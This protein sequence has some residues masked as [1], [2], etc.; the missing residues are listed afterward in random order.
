MTKA[1]ELVERVAKALQDEE[2]T[3][4]TEPEMLDWLSEAQIAVARTPSAYTITCLHHLKEG[5][6]Q[7][8]PSDA[9]S[10]ITITRNFD[11]EGTPL[12]PVRIVARA[13][14]DA[15]EPDW[16]LQSRAPLVENYVYDDRSPKEFYVYPPNDGTG[17]VELT[18]CGIPA[19]IESMDDEIVLDDT[20]IPPLVDYMLYRAN[21]KET[22]YATGVQSASAFFASYQQELANAMS[23]R[24][25]LTPN[26]SMSEGAV[27]PNGG[28]E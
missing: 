24:G 5:T 21:A 2:L 26:A 28:T 17:I 3:R 19:P 8:M 13:L 25:I 22:D 27:N 16:H 23:A 6:R 20:F 10:L 4:W 12:Y 14:L 7:Y 9:W 15:C 11:E 1:R 18:Y